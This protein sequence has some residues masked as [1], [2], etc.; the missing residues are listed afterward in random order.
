MVNPAAATVLNFSDETIREIE[1]R[2]RPYKYPRV[3][4]RDWRIVRN[5]DEGA[6]YFRAD[7]LK[8]IM[9]CAQERDERVWLHV[10]LSRPD[11]MP[12]YDDM[13]EVK[14]VFIGPDKTA[15][16]LF[17]PDTDH[18]NL[19]S[20]CLHLWSCLDGPVTPDFTRGTGSI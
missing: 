14:R 1:E 2:A 20:H 5:C 12:T 8:V 17:V 16:Q 10:S 9:S 11:R 13:A 6:I 19:H 15:Y 3:M 4:P 7:R 18:V